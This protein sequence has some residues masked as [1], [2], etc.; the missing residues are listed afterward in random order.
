MAR[1]G[2]LQEGVLWEVLRWVVGATGKVWKKKEETKRSIT[3][4]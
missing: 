2:G 4:M 3:K 1:G